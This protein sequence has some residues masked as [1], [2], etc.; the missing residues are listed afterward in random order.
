MSGKKDTPKVPDLTAA[1]KEMAAA[2]QRLTDIETVNKVTG[3]ALSAEEKEFKAAQARLKEKGE[4]LRETKAAAAREQNRAATKLEQT[5]Q[6]AKTEKWATGFSKLVD[7]NKKFL[8]KDKNKTLR[9]AF[10]EQ[11]NKV[12]VKLDCAPEDDCKTPSFHKVWI[13]L[14]VLNL[15]TF[16]ASSMVV[17]RDSASNQ[18]DEFNKTAFT[19]FDTD[20]NVEVDTD[21]DGQV[22]SRRKNC[23]TKND[24]VR[25]MVNTNSGMLG[26]VMGLSLVMIVMGVLSY[27]ASSA[28]STYLN[29]VSGVI[30]VVMIAP[31]IVMLTAENI[32]NRADKSHIKAGSIG[33]TAGVATAATLSIL[34]RQCAIRLT[35]SSTVLG[36]KGTV[37][38]YGFSTW[39]SMI[40]LCAIAGLNITQGALGY[41]SAKA[42][43]SV[44]IVQP[45]EA[46]YGVSVIIG[47]ISIIGIPSSFAFMK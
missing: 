20:T 27:A 14:L 11:M 45:G 31:V 3:S 26:F 6:Y 33:Y 46:S 32:H 2:A 35:D 18:E 21:D 16:F 23:S 47:I 42:C 15:I 12:R 41:T 37:K 13:G 17:L 1:E 43:Q 29:I 8:D 25:R 9:R 7:E 4:R 19:E 39:A 22:I 30:S 38:Q 24:D 36:G 40:I 10:N 44:G 5:S 34:L 28:K